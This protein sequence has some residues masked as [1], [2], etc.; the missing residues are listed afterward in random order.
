MFLIITLLYIHRVESIDTAKT[1]LGLIC[2]VVTILFFAAPLASLLHVIKVK[3][4][5]SLP[6]H[7]IFATFIVSLQWL[8]YGIVLGDKFIQVCI[9]ILD[10][11]KKKIAFLVDQDY[12]FIRNLSV[13]NFLVNRFTIA[14]IF[15]VWFLDT[16]FS[17]MCPV[18][19]P[20]KFIYYLS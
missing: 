16:Q 19:I 10:I 13:I 4:T 14:L 15:F 1:N 11:I 20:V 5:D 7:L 2:C 12:L 9:Y 3:S 17:R 8:I 6:Y 18:G